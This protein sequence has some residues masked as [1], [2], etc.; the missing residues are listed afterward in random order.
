M[1]IVLSSTGKRKNST[2]QIS[3][4]TSYS[5]Y[6]KE[7]TSIEKPVFILN[8]TQSNITSCTTAYC[9]TFGTYYFIDDIISVAND[10]WEVS[11]T[12]DVLATYKSDIVSSDG[13][14]EYADTTIND[15]LPDRRLTQSKD[16]IEN[17]EVSSKI[18]NT[19]TGFYILTTASNDSSATVGFTSV[20]ALTD[21]NAAAV[22]NWLYDDTLIDDLKKLFNDP[23]EA[24]IEA[25]FVPFDI[26]FGTATTVRVGTEN[27]GVQAAGLYRIP[28]QSNK[29]VT[30][31]VPYE[32]GKTWKD[33]APY[34]K[35]FL[36]LPFYGQ[37]EVPQELFLWSDEMTVKYFH[38]PVSG[39]VVY[40]CS[41]G[42]YHETYRT[43]AAV[44]LAIGQASKYGIEGIIQTATGLLTAG[45]LLSSNPLAGAAGVSA[46]LSKGA[47]TVGTISN[48]GEGLINTFNGSEGSKG[49]NGGFG[50][51]NY[52]LGSGTDA[53]ARRICLKQITYDF[54]NDTDDISEIEGVPVNE[55]HTLSDFSGFVKCKA[56]SI[57]CNA[58]NSDLDMINQFVNS[59][60]FIE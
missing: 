40:N 7:N 8:A 47:L 6:L 36:Y 51:A 16:T 56:F 53:T 59:G 4:G 29:T 27:S 15:M 10:L 24:I 25:H 20:Y 44:S 21:F 30:V 22:A 17:A 2:K 37:V 32:W 14:I 58:R 45:A 19:T 18:V 9:S 52:V 3:T 1:N 42:V 41:C 55:V 12:L 26:D 11:C 5:V 50:S 54:V 39:E 46:M 13:Y 60:F 33:S 34:S 38:D 57:D 35:Y 43:S 49:G 23:Y 28:I 31:D 48:I